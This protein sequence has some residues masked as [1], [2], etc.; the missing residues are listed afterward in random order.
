MILASAEYLD[1]ET[2]L[3]HLPFLNIDEIDEILMR[4]DEEEAD[5][6]ADEGEDLED[7]DEGES[8][9]LDDTIAMLEDMI[10]GME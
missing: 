7:E 9:D 2:I 1:D 3:K 4:K 6:F 8:S 5:R 10:K